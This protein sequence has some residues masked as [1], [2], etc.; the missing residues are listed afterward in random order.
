[1]KKY[2]T[3]FDLIHETSKN[4]LNRP[5]IKFVSNNEEVTITYEKFY[6]D[7]LLVAKQITSISEEKSHFAIL[8]QNSY[9]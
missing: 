1:M 9:E 3:L 7:I 2:S 5:A 4:N 6:E 8:S